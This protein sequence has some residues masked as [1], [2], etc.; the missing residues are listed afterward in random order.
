VA[1]VPSRRR[2]QPLALLQLNGGL[3]VVV[4]GGVLAFGVHDLQEAGVP[5]A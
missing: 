2:F 3:I 1:A 4:A 5:R